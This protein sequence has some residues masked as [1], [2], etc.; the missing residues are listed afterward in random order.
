MTMTTRSDAIKWPVLA[1]SLL[2]PFVAGG[3]GTLATN[4]G[5]KTWY[6]TLEKPGFNPPNWIFG[7][8]WSLLYLLMGVAHYQ[9]SQKQAGAGVAR[10]AQQ[11]YALQLG[12]NTL[13]SLIFFGR[14]S[15]GAALVEIAFL[16]VAILLTILTFARV[17]RPAAA[18]LVP[19]LAWVSFATLLNAAIWRLNR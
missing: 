15:L 13:W 11:L 6:P 2:L 4:E 8:V 12:L 7:P 17:S 14:R 19:Y 5:L 9:V 16:W 18:L 3:L 10:Q 1:R